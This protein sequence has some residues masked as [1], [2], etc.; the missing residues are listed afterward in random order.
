[1]VSERL[2][3]TALRD[4][5]VHNRD[6]L[7]IATKGGLRMTR[8]R[9]W[10]VT[11]SPEWLRHG[12]HASLTALGVDYIDL[13]QVHW[14]DPKVPVAETAEALG[15]ARCGRQD[16]PRRGCPTTTRSRSTSSPRP[17]RWRRVQPP[18]HLFRREIEH[19]LLPYSSAHDIGVLVYGPLG[20]RPADRN[21]QK[22]R[23]HSPTTTGAPRA[24]CSKG[25][26]YRHNLAAARCAGQVRRRP[27]A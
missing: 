25:E 2:L 17:C 7:V 9:T 16:P 20:P 18:Y 21:D 12:V 15:G 24:P 13:Y 27:V 23:P 11:H 8:L 19:E 26:T 22:S 14:P 4:E 1:M 6:Q 10:S 5:L 3:G